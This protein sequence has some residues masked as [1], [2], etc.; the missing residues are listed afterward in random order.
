MHACVGFKNILHK[1]VRDGFCKLSFRE[2]MCKFRYKVQ[3]DVIAMSIRCVLESHVA[4]FELSLIECKIIG[5]SI[6]IELTAF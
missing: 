4:T 3:H 5:F 6:L 2:V 1:T